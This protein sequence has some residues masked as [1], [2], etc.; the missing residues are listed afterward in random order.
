MSRRRNDENPNATSGRSYSLGSFDYLVEDDIEAVVSRISQMK[1]E[2]E[3]EMADVGAPP[4]PGEHVAEL[5][6][7]GR[8]WLRDYVDRITSSA[9]SS[10]NSLRFSGRWSARWSHRPENGVA[11]GDSRRWDVEAAALQTPATGDEATFYAIYR[12]IVG[13]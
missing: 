10:F 12:W 6:G 2:K 9:S 11:A 4:P 1:E 3:A 8:G 7:E 13:I 5:A